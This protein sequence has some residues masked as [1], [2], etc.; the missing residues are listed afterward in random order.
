MARL[1]DDIDSLA[2]RTGF[3]G[4]VHA[5]TVGGSSS[6]RPTAWPT[7]PTGSRTPSG[8]PCTI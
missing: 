6:R 4:V 8:E 1:E 2:E 5:E 7:A 3:S